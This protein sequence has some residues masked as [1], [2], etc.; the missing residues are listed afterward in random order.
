MARLATGEEVLEQAQQALAQAKTVDELRQAQAVM[1]PLRFGLSI[2]QTASVLGVSRGWACQLRRRFIR[3][4]G[5]VHTPERSRPSRAHL[6]REQEAAFLAP[7]LDKAAVGG[8][9]VAA[10]IKAALEAH[11]DRRV[12]LS[13]VYNLMHRHGWRKLAPD[14]QHPQADPAAQR[15]W[16]KKLTPQAARP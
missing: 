1:L 4:S 12:A 2:E 11:L 7:F 15:R 16:K 9:L 5:L 3:H 13:T 8:I 14:R 10:E 6:T